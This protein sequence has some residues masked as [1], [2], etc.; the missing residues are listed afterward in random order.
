MTDVA[1]KKK[2]LFIIN[3]ISGVN[4]GKKHTIEEI[5]IRHLDHIVYDYS[6]AYTQLPGHATDLAKDAVGKNYFAVVA[7]GGD[8]SINEIAKA[9]TGSKTVLAVIPSGSGNG[10]AHHLHIPFVFEKAIEVINKGRVISIDTVHLND[11][12][13]ISI[14]GVGFDALVAKKFAKK[15]RRGFLSYFSIVSREY[16]RYK[17]KSY[18]LLID[19]KPLKRRALFISFANSDQFGYNTRIAPN[20]EITDGLID[21]CIVKKIPLLKIPILAHFLFQRKIDKSNYVECYKAKEIKVIRKKNRVINIDGEAVK[22]SKDI[23][24]KINHLSLNVIVP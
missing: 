1:V 14:A 3:P 24:I 15:K 8:G 5:I 19:G 4:Q 11:E 6:I 20:A 16:A 7:I 9:L 21:V 13:F 12:I 22:L 18:K 17:P 10:F 23:S 2:I